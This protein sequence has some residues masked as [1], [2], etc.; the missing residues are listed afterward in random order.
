MFRCF[1]DAGYAVV[2]TDRHLSDD[3]AGSERR[4][5]GAKRR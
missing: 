3:V 1:A 5:T 4:G 2:D